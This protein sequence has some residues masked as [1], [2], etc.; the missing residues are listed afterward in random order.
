MHF[1]M[2]ILHMP[3]FQENAFFFFSLFRD[4]LAVYGNSQARSSIRA[5][6]AGPTPQ[7]Q[8]H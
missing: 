2:L 8:Q 6:A 4:A 1:R 3:I 5:L 7:P